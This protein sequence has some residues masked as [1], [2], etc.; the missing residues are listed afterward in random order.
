[1]QYNKMFL[2]YLFFKKHQMSVM[3]GSMPKTQATT[4]EPRPP[5]SVQYQM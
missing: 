1:M 3:T 2:Q 4:K 5:A